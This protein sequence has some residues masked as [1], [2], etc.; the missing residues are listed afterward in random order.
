[1]Y[2]LGIRFVGET[3]AKTVANAIHDVFELELM[4]E[5]QLQQMEDIGVKVAQSIYT[6]FRNGENIKMLQQLKELGLQMY[7]IK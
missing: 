3:T 2:A 7:N 6:F 5:E 1:I 4:N